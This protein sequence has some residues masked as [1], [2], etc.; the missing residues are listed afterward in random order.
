[1]SATDDEPTTS[2]IG[3]S[4]L[5]HDVPSIGWTALDQ[6]P[7]GVLLCTTDGRIVYASRAIEEIFGHPT[8]AL[9]GEKVET[10]LPQVAREAHVAHRTAYADAPTRRPMSAVSPLWGRHA[11]GHQIP[12]EVALSPVEDPDGSE[13]WIMAAVR[14]ISDRQALVAQNE[15]ILRAIDAIGDGVFVFEADSLKFTY[16]NQAAASQTGHTSEELTSGLTPLDISSTLVEPD[17][18][19]TLEPLL[20]GRINRRTFTMHHTG[21]SGRTTPYEVTLEAPPPTASHAPPVII[22]LTRDITERL[23]AEDAERA[24]ADERQSLERWSAVLSDR[25]RI[26]RDLH[27][28]VIQRLF[29]VGM[30]L[31][32][33]ASRD[34]SSSAEPIEAVV[35]ELD[36]VISDIRSSIFQLQRR[37]PRPPLSERLAEIISRHAALT[38]TEIRANL[39][40]GEVVDDPRVVDELAACAEEALSNSLRHSGGRL[41]S[42]DL[43]HRD[44]SLVLT[45]TDDGVGIPDGF[46][47][48]NGLANLSA[49]AAALGGTCVVERRSIPGTQ[50]TVS[51][52]ISRIEND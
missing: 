38:P 4:P 22:A 20:S 6:S 24:A 7:D 25:E 29:A 41:I 44:D 13:R 48:G 40:P 11:A 3:G 14:D 16:A 5:R 15:L 21:Q 30:Q 47:P 10:L 17:V 27:D 35:T 28:M 49:R 31:Q 43:D 19:A 36:E 42:V 32:S 12:I 2:G 46:E 51:V 18:R 39:E 33:A 1:M 23:E 45:V 9:V 50:V 37:A 52:P 34:D 8:G 26:A